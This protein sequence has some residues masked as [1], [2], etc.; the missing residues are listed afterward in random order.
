MIRS[1]PIDLSE[2]ESFQLSH[3]SIEK[4]TVGILWIDS[5]ARVYRANESACKMLGFTMEELFGMSVP[6]FDMGF[7]M[8]RF[9]TAWEMHKRE[10]ALIVES[11]Y[12]AKDGRII[13]VEINSYFVKFKGREYSCAFFRDITEKKQREN[14]LKTALTKLNIL[15]NRLKEENTYLREEIEVEHN[16][17]EIIGQSRVLR[18]LLK[19]VTQVASTDATVL[20]LGETGTGKELIARAVH[21]LSIRKDRSLVKVNCAALPHNLIESALFGHKKGAFTGALSDNIGKFELADG[22]TIFLDEIGELPLELQT[23]LLRVLQ[24]GEVE[25]LGQAGGTIK[26]DVRV[27]AATNRNLEKM[28]ASNEFRQDLYYRLNVF[29]IKCPPLRDRKGD[30]PVLAKHFLDK[31]N[32]KIGR[33]VSRISK[34]TMDI[35]ERYYWPGN[36]REL[37]NIIERA[38]IVSPGKEL[39]IG[40]WFFQDAPPP[41]DGGNV[42]TLQDVERNHIKKV[43]ESTSWRVSGKGGVA[44]KLGL[45]PTTLE[46]RMKKLEILRPS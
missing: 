23:K 24:D 36:V 22:G 33:K 46:A 2:D 30:I 10:G 39:T 11:R 35:L 27:I 37:E 41:S 8:E 43:L 3:V 28:I 9:K 16:F 38:L 15:Q 45:K 1:N 19:E 6:D 7:P 12:K 21:N 17:Q 29:P 5:R 44:E 25:K 4:A 18:H 32:S 26:V 34:K 14:E 13:P 31:Y 40:N 42:S 20:L